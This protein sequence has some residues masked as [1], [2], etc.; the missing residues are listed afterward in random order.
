MYMFHVQQKIQKK[1]AVRSGENNRS[2]ENQKC[3]SI[4]RVNPES[5]SICEP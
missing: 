2:A 4:F 5:W 1:E 3:K